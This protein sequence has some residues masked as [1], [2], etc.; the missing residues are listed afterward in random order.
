VRLAGSERALARGTSSTRCGS[1]LVL[2]GYG[3]IGRE[4]AR[5]AAALRMRIIAVKA[6][7]DV[8][9]ASG[10]VGPGTGD[11]DRSLPE[12]V[13]GSGGLAQVAAQAVWLVISLPLTEWTRHLVDARVLAAMHAGDRAQAFAGGSWR[14]S[15]LRRER[16]GG[17]CRVPRGGLEANWRPNPDHT[18]P[19]EAFSAAGAG[20]GGTTTRCR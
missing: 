15:A 9:A 8:L 2:V 19:T 1:T 10:F 16:T 14:P 13:V 6:R 17:R 20:W 3:S 18:C 4:V 7:P 12:Q 11:P 5:L